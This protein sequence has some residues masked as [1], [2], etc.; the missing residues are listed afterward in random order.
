M[1]E[2]EKTKPLHSYFKQAMP[3]PFMMG[4]LTEFNNHVS[5]F[6]ND[7]ADHLNCYH[8]FFVDDVQFMASKS[9]Q[10]ELR[11]LLLPARI[12]S[13]RWDLPVYASKSQHLPI[14]QPPDF[15]LVP[16]EEDQGKSI[17]S[18]E[19]LNDPGRMVDSAFTSSI[20]VITVAMG[21]IA[22][23]KKIINLSYSGDHRIPI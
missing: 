9:Q 1:S 22:I 17:R 18:C 19:Q 6:F 16:S 13:S 15:H 8:L 2:V 7:L 14:G 4:V 10:Q 20:N 21:N 12:R 23:H 11:S 3:S 5:D